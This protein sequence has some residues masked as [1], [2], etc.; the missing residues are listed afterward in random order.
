M[1]LLIA[2]TLGLVAVLLL[3][4]ARGAVSARGG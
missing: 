1:S 3:V 4:G 2:V